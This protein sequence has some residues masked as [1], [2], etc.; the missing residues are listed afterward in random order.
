MIN[1]KHNMKFFKKI[2]GN[3]K[4]HQKILLKVKYIKVEFQSFQSQINSLGKKQKEKDKG[5]DI[6]VQKKI[7]NYV[8][9]NKILR[10]KKINYKKINHK[11]KNQKN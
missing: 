5:I 10:I 1:N 4:E 6:S 7:K 9:Q 3:L 11:N 8:Q 2:F